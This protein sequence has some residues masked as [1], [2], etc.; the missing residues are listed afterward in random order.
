VTPA[1]AAEVAR[2]LDAA[3]ADVMTALAPLVGRHD[4]AALLSAVAKVAGHMIG[5]AHD[6]QLIQGPTTATVAGCDL[7]LRRG[8]A[9]HHERTRPGLEGRA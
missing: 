9:E 2:R 5:L 1:R 4:A 7:F 3:E 8:L 6:R